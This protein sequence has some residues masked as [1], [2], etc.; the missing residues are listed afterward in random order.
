MADY[1]PVTQYLP[2]SQKQALL[3]TKIRKMTKKKPGKGDTSSMT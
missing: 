1:A 2:K 3:K